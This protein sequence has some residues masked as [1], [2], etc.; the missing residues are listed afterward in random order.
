MI[1]L[2]NA[3]RLARGNVPKRHHL[4]YRCSVLATNR[5]LASE[6]NLKR[7]LHNSCA[8]TYKADRSYGN[9]M[10]G[11]S[12]ASALAAPLL[13]WSAN[14]DEEA[15][16]EKRNIK[17]SGCSVSQQFKME[18][19]LYWEGGDQDPYKKDLRKAHLLPIY[20]LEQ[21]RA[22]HGE[23]T[24]VILDGGVYDVTTF[25]EAHPGGASRIQMVNGND[26]STYWNVYML[27]DR[28][29]IRAL[30]ERY[31]IGNLTPED[32]QRAK[33]T[34]PEFG[35]YYGSDPVRPRESELRI[36]TRAPWNAE[37]TLNVL[38]DHFFTPND[39]FFVRNHNNV[40]LFEE[41]EYTLSISA[42]DP[43][44]GLKEKEYTLDEL[45][46]K[47]P[48]AEIVATLQCAGNRQE[49]FVQRDRPLYVAPHWR[50]GAIGNARW[51]GVRVRDVLSDVGI[52]V[53]GM[54]LRKKEYPGMK[55]VNFIGADTDETGVNYAGVLPM[56]KVIDPF[57][58]AIL[59][60]E[61]NGETLPRDHGYPLRLV[62][63]G[64]AGC[65]NVKW[66]E[67]IHVSKNVSEL[68]SGSKLDRHFAPDVSF[69]KHI[70]LGDERLRLDQGPVIQT[71]PVQSIICEPLNGATLDGAD[72]YIVVRGV[73][74]SGAGRGV[75]RVELSLDGGE[76]FT[77]A[78]I[79][80]TPGSKFRAS[81]GPDPQAGQG[82]NWSWNQ[83]Y[84]KARIPDKNLEELK[85]GT[86]SELEICVRA[87]DGDFNAQPE[88]MEQVWNVLGI[89]VNH[90]HKI[91]VTLDPHMSLT[92]GSPQF[93]LPNPAGYYARVDGKAPGM[94]QN[95]ITS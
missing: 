81:S 36:P 13:W 65:R 89:C 85:S 30:L 59:A 93:K 79:L 1:R 47:F 33:D 43:N 8:I 92:N 14:A 45:K 17:D 22:D 83:Y 51:T 28:P 66:V 40:P 38:V 18:K 77:A 88:K 64:H 7:N 78:E 29:H 60:Y 2:L 19:E 63:P 74:W 70:R 23:E 42:E 69:L 4:S 27:H 26:L 55:I 87:I 49:D 95:N 48:V 46:T 68:D 35:D 94:Y 37:P 50:N 20:T 53:D 11:W 84:L 67:E 31:R 41:D 3:G 56:E 5:H 91:S 32:A 21:V 57:G 90:W 10:I 12:L 72:E 58:D 71:L 15:G 76:T 6:H 16:D 82:R 86:K 24:W 80:P 25:L 75:C 34:T 54:A 52:D 73:A 44:W 9:R 61:M 62:A 39:L